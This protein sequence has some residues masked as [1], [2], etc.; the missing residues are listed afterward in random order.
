MSIQLF[1]LN[2]ILRF[3]IKRR[4]KKKPDILELRPVMAEAGAMQKPVPADI[5]VA[6]VRIGGVR[7]ERL[8]AHDTRTDAAFLYIHGG[9]WVAGSPETHRSLTWRLTK[10]IGI[11]VF[12]ID[13]RLAP[14]HPFPAGLDD[15]VA[16]YRGL[17]ASGVDASSIV[18]GGDSAGGN[19]TMALAVR[20]RD[21]GMPMPAA[22]VC[23]SPALDFTYSGASVT[24]NADADTFFIP[25]IMSTVAPIYHPGTDA[26]HP[27]LSPVFGDASGLPPTLFQVGATEMLRDDS[28]RMAAN[29][30][31][32]GNANVQLDVWPKVWHVWQIMA[33]QLPEGEKAIRDIVSFVK[34]HLPQPTPKNT[35]GNT[36]MLKVHH[37]NNSRS[38]R[39]LWLLEEL[40]LPYEIIKYQRDAVTNLAPPELKKIHPLGKSP[41]IEDDGRIIAESGAIV[42]LITQKYGKGKLAPAQGTPAYDRY[43]EWLHF[44]EGSAMLPLMLALYTGRL[45]DAAAPL[46]PRITS[47]LD[48]YFSYMNSLV[49]KGGYLMGKEF[50]AADIENSFVLEAG[51]VR[52][53]LANYPNLL[54]LLARLQAR[55]AYKAALEKGGAYAFA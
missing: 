50:S 23:L 17:I 43:I 46:Q 54:D 48:N 1:L 37:L 38:Q 19:L 42:E 40:Q 21:E 16:A 22:L 52:G 6:P 34:K 18:V 10:Q 41:V 14:E 9:G 13:Y 7:A 47:E 44:A 11:P 49:E 8:A 31:A 35:T 32:A 51:K 24:E 55:P 39:I 4:F 36:P 33:D 3:R 20:L 26:K 29:M 53:F 2:P 27:Y 5:D 25:E 12:A 30:K 15:C 45:G 28:T